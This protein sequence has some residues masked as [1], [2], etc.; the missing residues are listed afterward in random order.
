[1]TN[2][3]LLQQI[4]QTKITHK[5]LSLEHWVKFEVFTWQWWLGVACVVVP[6]VIWLKVV[7]KRRILEI[8]V[9]GLLV[10][11]ASIFLDVTGS[12]FVLW[13]YDIRILP[14]IPLLFPVDF[15]LLPIIFMLIYQHYKAWKQFII[16]SMITASIL[17]FIIEPMA[18]YIK[19]YTLFS[20]RFMYSFPI[21]IIIV[22]VS[23]MITNKMLSEQ[24]KGK[25]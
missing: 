4:I 20:W 15:I 13:N 23:K 21:Y 1:M 5:D 2:A 3:E 14:S 16:A 8:S 24:G 7:D 11:V 22:I 18:V 17:A 9:F 19:Q 6:L 12:E 10:N 25:N